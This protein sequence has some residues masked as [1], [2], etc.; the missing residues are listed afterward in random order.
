MTEKDNKI[1]KSINNKIRFLLTTLKY[2]FPIVLSFVVF[3]HMHT[4]R[5]TFVILIEVLI[6]ALISEL[7]LK[8]KKIGYIFNSILML[9]INSQVI[10]LYFANSYIEL[11][12]ITNMDAVEDLSGKAFSYIL[13]IVFV[14]VFSFLPIKRLAINERGTYIGTI[15]LLFLELLFTCMYGSSYS[16]LYSYIDLVKQKI[17][18]DNRVE[19]A[20]SSGEK[21]HL[22][23]QES[24]GDY[25]EAP[26]NLSSK[27]NIVLIFTEGIS[28]NIVEDERN[29]TPN[30]NSFQSKAI[31]FSDYYNHTFAT[32]RGLIGQLYSGYQ[33]EDY[34]ENSLISIEEVLKEKGYYTCFI[35]TEPNNKEF[36]E[37]LNNLEFDDV[38]GEPGEYDGGANSLSDKSAYEELA[39]VISDC[40]KKDQPYFVVIYTFGTHASLDSIDQDFGDGNSALLNKFYDMDYQFGKFFDEYSESG[41]SDDSILIFTGD[42][43]T[44]ADQ[45]F[46]DAFPDYQR[47]YHA[48]DRMPL[49]IWYKGVKPQQISANGR[50]SLDLAPTIMDFIDV[51]H[52]N[53]FLGSSLF[54]DNKTYCD[55]VFESLGNMK[56]TTDSNIQSLSREEQQEY[57]NYIN[58]YFAAKT[59]EPIQTESY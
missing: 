43:C 34:D 30:I 46:S 8:K 3:C 13:G 10:V 48:L 15:A 38:I 6:V 52:G 36:T 59:Q 12:M 31:T 32:Y 27:P 54:S 37:Y 26:E 18:H 25:I 53:Y 49:S 19:I 29:I 50:N 24:V 47:D 57:L 39:C 40:E 55:T 42:H 44:Y 28:Q 9:L 56:K 11:V 23:Y 14:I 22:F 7:L 17:D 45:D 5:Y 58:D 4:K 51:D 2:L 20:L 1:T 41:V 16:P 33:L 21:T 35:N